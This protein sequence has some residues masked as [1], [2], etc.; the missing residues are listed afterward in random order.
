MS[1]HFKVKHYGDNPVTA[2]EIAECTEAMLSKFELIESALQNIQHLL[3]E[4]QKR[5]AQ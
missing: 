1:E 2:R 3:I 4:E 5:R